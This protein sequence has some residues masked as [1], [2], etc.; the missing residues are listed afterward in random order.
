MIRYALKIVKTHQE[1]FSLRIFKY[2]I[3]NLT[4]TDNSELFR[5]VSLKVIFENVNIFTVMPIINLGFN[6]VFILIIYL[7]KNI[8]LY[9]T[10]PK[11]YNYYYNY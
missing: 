3:R 7:N 8:L 10:H 11:D 9:V 4:P 2:H 1:M 6:T 5:S